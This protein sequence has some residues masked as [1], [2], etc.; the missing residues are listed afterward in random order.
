MPLVEW[1]KPQFNYLGVVQMRT[2]THAIAE[3]VE[4]LKTL[5]KHHQFRTQF[6]RETARLGL[7]AQISQV[8]VKKSGELK[9]VDQA[10]ISYYFGFDTWQDAEAFKQW[11]VKSN[12]VLASEV[13]NPYPNVEAREAKRLTTR[14]EVKVRNLASIANTLWSVFEKAY[15]R[16]VGKADLIQEAFAA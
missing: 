2:Y 10:I 5:I 14:Y 3:S 9:R 8:M 12:E 13:N 16:E 1:Q 15:Q 4:E 6:L 7:V 11:L